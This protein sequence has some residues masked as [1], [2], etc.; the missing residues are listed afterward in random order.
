MCTPR[1]HGIGCRPYVYHTD[2]VT[3]I[4]AH[5]LSLQLV[6]D[7]SYPIAQITTGGR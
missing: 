6:T 7:G 1:G 2:I 3:N 5:N 4:Q